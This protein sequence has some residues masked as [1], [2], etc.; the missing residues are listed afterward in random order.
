M[1]RLLYLLALLFTLTHL[2]AQSP[3]PGDCLSL[4]SGAYA[5]L[6]GAWG[7]NFSQGN[8]TVECYF[9][10]NNSYSD[11]VGVFT[12]FNTFSGGWAIQKTN[13]GRI[14][15][16]FGESLATGDFVTIESSSPILTDTWHHVA[17]IKTGSILNLYLNGVFEG[18]ASVAGLVPP[19]NVTFRLG[20]RYL[21]DANNPAFDGEIDELRVWDTA[22]SISVLRSWISR[23]LSSGTHP[24]NFYLL[25]HFSFDQ[26]NGALVY[27]DSGTNGNVILISG[28]TTAASRVPL[29]DKQTYVLN[30]S[31]GT[32]ISLAHP[33]GDEMTVE[34]TS[35]PSGL[36]VLYYVDE[37]PEESAAPSGCENLSDLRYWG[38]YPLVSTGIALY[39]ISYNYDGH[40]GINTEGNLRLCRRDKNDFT[41]DL[42]AATP[43]EAANT[44]SASFAFPKEFILGSTAGNPLPVELLR[45]TVNDNASKKVDLEWETASESDNAYF[46]VERS[47]NGEDWREIGRLEGQIDSN[48]PSTYHY[49]DEWPLAGWNYYRLR[50]VDLDGSFVFSEV[51]SVW[52][53][54]EYT[55]QSGVFPNPVQDKLHLNIES[56]LRGQTWTIFDQLGRHLSTGVFGDQASSDGV[57]LNVSSLP[58][59]IYVLSIAGEAFRF[60]KE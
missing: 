27:A 19:S 28:A 4:S 37:G 32:I 40:P 20:R 8:F 15:A 2:S 60:V 39:D 31:S 9:K 49:T 36:L 57:S 50:Q 12:S 34:L 51:E 48:N 53:G 52:I 13:N 18:S 11:T 14:R 46:S 3:G 29:G 55:G 17:L 43:D 30:P 58:G 54:I 6:S 47:D 7:P 5:S 38:V 42:D 59:G 24:S 26:V 25:F 22:L 41:W 56:N 45:F 44:L 23:K 1:N 35:S 10:T 33:D 16:I 21:N